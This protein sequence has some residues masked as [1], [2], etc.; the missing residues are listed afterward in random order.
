MLVDVELKLLMDVHIISLSTVQVNIGI[1]DYA[2]PK[3]RMAAVWIH[4]EHSPIMQ[5][6]GDFSIPVL[7]GQWMSGWC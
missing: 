4:R 2:D 7:I 5:L 6:N 1:F 3:D